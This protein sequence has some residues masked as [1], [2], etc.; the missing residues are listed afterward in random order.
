[1]GATCT[2]TLNA[3][4]KPRATRVLWAAVLGTPTLW[5]IHQLNYALVQFVCLWQ[6]KWLLP[7]ITV[8][9][10]ALTALGT[11]VAVRAW[12]TSRSSPDDIDPTRFLAGLG[13]MNGTLFFVT[14]LTTGIATFFFN[15]CPD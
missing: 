3:S 6:R 14:I 13:I 9:F 10:L 8:V 5:A 15:P 2:E 4:K 11:L 7:G 12:R 1:M